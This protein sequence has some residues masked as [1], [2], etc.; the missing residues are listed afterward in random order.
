MES[1]KGIWLALLS[2][3]LMLEGCTLLVAGAAGGTGAGTVAYIKGELKATYAAPLNRTWEASLDA[4]KA[5]D[6]QVSRAEKDAAGGTIEARRADGTSVKLS[7]E[8][9]GPD[10][11]TV[12]V[13]IGTFGDQ[14]AS[15]A[16]HRQI[17]A[18]LGA[19]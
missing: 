19:K 17:A 12:K 18:H 14:E 2:V 13:R 1:A 9:A 7:V 16:I 11:T 5:L 4:L 8:P 3:S 10:T 15:Q 6:I